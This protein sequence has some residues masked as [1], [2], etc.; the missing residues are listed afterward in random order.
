[1]GCHIM[2]MPFRALGLDIPISVKAEVEPEW[3]AN[4]GRR[5]ET[6]PR[7]QIVRYLYPGTDF[8]AG[9]TVK[10]TWSDGGKYPPEELRAHIGGKAWPTQGA[11]MIGEDGA[12]M[13]EHGAGPR[14]YPQDRFSTVKAPKLSP[15]HHYHQFIDAILGKNG[16]KTHSPFSYSA[17]STEMVLLGTVALRFPGQELAWDAASMGFPKVEA[18]NRYV[19]RTYRKGWEVQGL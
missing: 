16:G 12:L 11:L 13:L 3:A 8:T 1:M 2:D 18:A 14:L 6:F 5:T 7:W 19:R 9:D 17:R 10:I 4:P 15:Q